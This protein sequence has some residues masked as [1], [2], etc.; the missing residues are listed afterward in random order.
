MGQAWGGQLHTLAQLARRAG[1]SEGRAR[2]LAA[3]PSPGLPRPDRF[4]AD[5]RP[6]WWSATIDRWCASTGR[7]VNDDALWLFNV[8]EATSTPVEL[9]R[10]LV[11]L[12]RVW[13]ERER[14]FTIV[15]DTPCGHVIYILAVDEWHHRDDLAH[16]AAGL[17]EPR[18]W[19]TAVVVMPFLESLPVNDEP[20]AHL[21][22]LTTA[23]DPQN[24]RRRGTAVRSGSSPL[25]GLRRLMARVPDADLDDEADGDEGRRAAEP[26]PVPPR[27]EWV[28]SLSMEE[29]A[30]PLGA[31]LPVWIRG[32]LTEPYISRSLAY[33]DTF[34][35]PDGTTGWPEAQQRVEHAVKIGLP[36]QYPAAW[37]VLAVDAKDRLDAIREAHAETPDTG[38][39]WYLVA[40]PAPPQVP[41]GLE[42][43]LNAAA[44]EDPAQAV[45]DLVALREAAAD[46][47]VDDQVGEVYTEAIALLS[48]QLKRQAN[49]QR[50]GRVFS[51]V[52]V[53][54][55]D[56]VLDQTLVSFSAPWAGPVIDEWKATLTWVENAAVALRQRRVVDLLGGNEP[57]DP[58][59]VDVVYR[60]R[61]GRYV[62]V[63]PSRGDNP[64]S[65]VAEWPAS[66][67]AVT[68]W[69]DRTVLAADHAHQ[70]TAI[71]ALTPT[72]DGQMRVD[73]LPLR[74]HR[75]CGNAF[76][77]GYNG[78]T[79]ATT[80]NAILRCALPAQHQLIDLRQYRMRNH[81]G[82]SP[83]SQLW[84]AI[85]TTKG[86]LRL[87]WSDVQQW[88]RIDLATA[89]AAA[90]PKRAER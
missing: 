32:T 27:A 49:H 16:A 88:A 80:Y 61:D 30:R 28:T 63:F 83:R 54:E 70:A 82:E 2:G 50:R 29:I 22:R 58:S 89:K 18:W 35:V 77:Y 55:L 33:N 31:R 79:P 85:A 52:T 73:P 68:A 9:R 34:T 24:R 74:G 59:T 39:G 6:L 15:W 84:E 69:N 57:V 64:P 46:L 26:P 45:A 86:P 66:L 11:Q 23:P 87:H 47:E 13:G 72:D 10:G 60:D 20:I 12:E 62:V 44:L 19:S 37:A 21:Y 25:S 51:S 7:A 40:R 3:K 5:G 71:L 78:G 42:S 43:R 8:D 53:A 41:V 67:D 38:P 76:A 14:F 36:E 17:I 81:D 1:I 75:A 90:R 4:D 48:L 56:A 65:F